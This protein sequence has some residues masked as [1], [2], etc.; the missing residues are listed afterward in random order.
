MSWGDFWGGVR[1]RIDAPARRLS[2]ITVTRDEHGTPRFA[3]HIP[4]TDGGARDPTTGHITSGRTAHQVIY[5]I[6]SQ[7]SLV[8][9]TT[10]E[11]GK[12]RFD[13]HIPFTPGGS[14][15]P[16]TGEIGDGQTA[17]ET[18]QKAAELASDVADDATGDLVKNLMPL[19]IV[20][21]LA[22]V[23]AQAV[24]SKGKGS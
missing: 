9:P 2:L 24:A 19:A 10:G 23:G 13:F 1:D 12:R 22:Y 3:A 15:D 8:T 4:G 14:L 5:P 7:L 6:A 17:G 21:A 18:V 11:D 16:Q 20:A